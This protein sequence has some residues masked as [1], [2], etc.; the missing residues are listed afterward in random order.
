MS[1]IY[2]QSYENYL[3]EKEKRVLA[4]IPFKGI[5]QGALVANGVISFGQINRRLVQRLVREGKIRVE[6]KRQGCRVYHV[7][8]KNKKKKK[9]RT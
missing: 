9:E 4:A 6:H 8:F 7:Y 3:K 1:R 2:R 5:S